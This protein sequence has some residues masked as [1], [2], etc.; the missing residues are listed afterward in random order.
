MLAALT[1][2]LGIFSWIIGPL[3]GIVFLFILPVV[4]LA[5]CVI[6]AVKANEGEAWSY[7]LTPNLLGE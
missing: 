4:N 1:H 6:A 2:V 5:F 7:P 3:I